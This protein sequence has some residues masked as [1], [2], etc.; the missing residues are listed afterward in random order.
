MELK[1]DLNKSYALALEG[2]GAKGAYQ[3]GAWKALKEAGIKLSAVSGT[4]VGALNGALITMDD[5]DTAVRCWEEIRY[6]QVMDVDDEA[7]QTIMEGDLKK[8]DPKVLWEHLRS[9]IEKGGFDVSPLLNMVKSIVDEDKIRSSPMEFYI[10]TYSLSDR[11]ELE[12]RAKDLAEGTIPD[13][14]LASAYL[15]VFKNEPLGGKRYADGG[16]RDVLPL[17]VLIENGCRDIIAIRLY[18][19]GLE[20]KVKIPEDCVVETIAPRIDLGNTLEFNAE[21]SRFNLRAGYFDAQRLL[22]GLKGNHFYIYNNWDERECYE[23]LEGILFR[24][25]KKLEK[26]VTLRE[27]HEHVLPALAKRIDT[28]KGD[29][30]DLVVP[31]L[32]NMAIDAQL[33]PWRIYTIAELSEALHVSFGSNGISPSLLE[34]LSPRKFLGGIELPGLN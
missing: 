31:V 17:H 18:G 8:L 33:D 6:S 19:I 12:L 32:E 26:D 11:K 34:D 1:L 2:G 27:F 22:Y 20:R 24:H 30:C 14:L 13:M 21:R 23:L 4:S 3:I 28:E 7:M 10:T 5:L 15:P 29:Y 9:T 25:L 16:F